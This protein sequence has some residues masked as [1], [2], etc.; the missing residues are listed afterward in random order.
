M[1][2]NYS[3]RL[4]ISSDSVADQRALENV[5]RY[6]EQQL[7]GRYQLTIIDVLEEPELAEAEGILLTPTL[8]RELP[9]PPQ[10]MVGDLSDLG[11]IAPEQYLN[12]T[13]GKSS[14]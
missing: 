14:S 6:C 11:A 13:N 3:F 8:L 1:A 4:F 10:R 2:Q 7:P 9:L 5:I 12:G